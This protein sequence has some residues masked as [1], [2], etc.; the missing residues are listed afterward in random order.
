MAIF[1]N[2]LFD[3]EGE[4]AEPDEGYYLADEEPT[5]C[6]QRERDIATLVAAGE[7]HQCVVCGCTELSPCAGGCIWAT[8]NLCSRCVL[9]AA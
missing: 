4:R 6:G 7:I 2:P 3:L 1:A 8:E 5:E 9:E